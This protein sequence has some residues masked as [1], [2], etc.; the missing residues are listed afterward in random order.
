MLH[1]MIKNDNKE[2]AEKCAAWSKVTK[3]NDRCM[4]VMY[5][6]IGNY[7]VSMHQCVSS[8]WLKLV[9]LFSSF[10]CVS[11]AFALEFTRTQCRRSFTRLL[12][13]CNPAWKKPS[14]FFV[15]MPCTF[16]APLA[17]YFNCLRMIFFK[18]TITNTHAHNEL[19]YFN[20]NI[21]SF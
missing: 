18:M 11:L 15:W 19:F 14:I 7:F 21:I 6:G 20:E 4:H 17:N 5:V 9:L 3:L 12:L 2:T 8:L 1:R 10:F 16:Q 13:R